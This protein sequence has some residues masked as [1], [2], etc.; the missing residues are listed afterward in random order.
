MKDNLN[1]IT[2]IDVERRMLV[3]RNHPILLDADVAGLYGVET[4][5]VNIR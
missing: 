3:L 1:Q 2:T 5:R 4:K